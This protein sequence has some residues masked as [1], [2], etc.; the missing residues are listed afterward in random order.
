VMFFIQNVV[1]TFIT[2]C[3]ASLMIVDNLE[4]Q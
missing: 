3:D 4:I 1:F 2:V